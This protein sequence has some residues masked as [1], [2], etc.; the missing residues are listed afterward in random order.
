MDER[1]DPVCRVEVSR[2]DAAIILTVEGQ[3][4]AATVG[5]FEPP[6]VQAV[7]SGEN[8]I[9]DLSAC[10]FIDSAVI[11]AIVLAKRCMKPAGASLRL[12]GG[13]V[14]QPLRALEITGLQGQVAVF[15]TLAAAVHGSNGSGRKQ[16]SAGE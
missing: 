12:V 2:S 7:E 6:L 8:V 15:P 13:E 11:A 10:T 1:D 14:S 9:V 3:L 4:D 5:D 16:A